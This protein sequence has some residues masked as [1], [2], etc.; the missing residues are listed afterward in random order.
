MDSWNQVMP[1]YWS[2]VESGGSHDRLYAALCHQHLAAGAHDLAV[3]GGTQ[4]GQFSAIM[5]C[6]ERYHR[7]VGLR[8]TLKSWPS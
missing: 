2:S 8:D 3:V 4:T 6:A 7:L 1:G 5:G